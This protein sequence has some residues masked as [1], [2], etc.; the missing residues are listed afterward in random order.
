MYFPRVLV[1]LAAV[2]APLVDLCVAFPLLLGLMAWYGVVPTRAILALPVFVGLAVATALAVSLWL[3]ALNVR[4][5]DVRHTVPFLVQ[6]LMYASPVVYPASV[7]PERFRA[8]YELNP[9]AGVIEGFRWALLGTPAPD[10]VT[11]AASGIVVA[12]LLVGGLVYFKRQEPAL[13]DLV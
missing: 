4:Y 1:P 12:G 3:S 7:V 5:R 13:A 6:V 10:P 11:L 2:A 9:M 8:L